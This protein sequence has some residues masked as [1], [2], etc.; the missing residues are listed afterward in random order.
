MLIKG[1]IHQTAVMGNGGHIG[2]LCRLLDSFPVQQESGWYKRQHFCFL[3]ISSVFLRQFLADIAVISLCYIWKHPVYYLIILDWVNVHFSSLLIQHDM[4][5]LH[6][7]IDYTSS[8]LQKWSLK[9]VSIY[10]YPCINHLS[11]TNLVS[12]VDWVLF[13]MSALHQKQT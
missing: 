8:C 13:P 9:Q 12:W 3:L 5:Y 10:I 2:E 11:W 4:K 1:I 7:F 6:H